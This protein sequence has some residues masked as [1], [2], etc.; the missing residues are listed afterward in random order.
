VLSCT[1]F[2][3]IFKFITWE[4]IFFSEREG[5]KSTLF[6]AIKCWRNSRKH[7]KR[8]QMDWSTVCTYPYEWTYVHTYECTYVCTYVWNPAIGNM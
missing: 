7:Q 5:V 8:F 3:I 6:D 2:Y 1:E 4:R